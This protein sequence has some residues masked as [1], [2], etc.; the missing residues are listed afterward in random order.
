[1]ECC[2]IVLS[3]TENNVLIEELGSYTV[4][5]S[6]L[7]ELVLHDVDLDILVISE[8]SVVIISDCVGTPGP[9]GPAGSGGIIVVIAG[10]TLQ[11]HSVVRILGDG[12]GYVADRNDTTHGVFVAGVSLFAALPGE[13]VEVMVNG[14]LATSTTWTVG[15]LYVGDAGALISTPP[16]GTMTD[17]QLQVCVAVTP[18]ELLVRPYIPI[19]NA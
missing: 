12:K 10:E 16:P 17:Y 11:Q 7:N 2:E 3:N 14:L 1:M 9:P 13:S 15:P 4:Y 6:F 5:N 8:P 19:F 18:N